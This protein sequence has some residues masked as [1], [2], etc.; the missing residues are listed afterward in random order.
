MTKEPITKNRAAISVTH[1]AETIKGGIATY[2]NVFESYSQ[3]LEFQNTYLI[4]QHQRSELRSNSNTKIFTHEGSR[5]PL[6]F[7]KLV[8]AIRQHINTYN[9]P[10]IFAHSTFAGLATAIALKITRHKPVF[11]YCSHG[12]ASLRDQAAWKKR[13]ITPIERLFSKR[14]D[15]IINI[16]KNEDIKSRQMKFG[17]KMY[18]I[19]NCAEES[20]LNLDAIWRR[21]SQTPQKLHLLYVGR[22]D[23]A[24]GFDILIKALSLLN[25]ERE[26]D[27]VID[28]IGEAVL[29]DLVTPIPIDLQPKIN[30]HGWVR[31]DHIDEFYAKADFLV[32]PSRNEGFG[33]CV[34]EAFRNAT[35]VIASNRGALP[36]I[37]Q[38]NINGIIFDLSAENLKCAITQ[39]ANLELLRLR[40]CALDTYIRNYTPQTFTQK[41]NKLISSVISN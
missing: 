27:F 2:L 20:K 41:L 37:V 1:I 10:L 33:I 34:I 32:V 36:N 23:K 35:P 22:F 38:H 15:A 31:N 39:A 17:Q 24:K 25:T 30:F 26:V 29:N 11:M 18:L 14:T 13:I 8:L 9:P 7:V 21:K 4:P 6:G 40:Q 19:E 5:K 16:S 12:W 28:V 3:N